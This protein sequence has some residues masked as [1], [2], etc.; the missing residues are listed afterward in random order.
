MKK[1]LLVCSIVVF[2]APLYSQSEW[3]L[4]D[5]LEYAIKNNI[6]I[7]QADIQTKFEKLNYKQSK[8]ALYPNFNSH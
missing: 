7:Q 4:K 2:S 6:S 3:S 1:N 8:L 5:C